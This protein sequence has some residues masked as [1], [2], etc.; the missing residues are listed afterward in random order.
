MKSFLIFL[1]RNKAY[2]FVNVFGLSISLMFI[3]LI[4]LYVYQEKSIDHQVANADRIEVWGSAFD[5]EPPCEG[6]HHVVVKY[7]MK[8]YPEI[9]SACGVCNGDAWFSIKG[10]DYT[11]KAMMVDTTF[12]H[13]FSY[14]LLQ[15][16]RRTCLTADNSIVVTGSFA[17]KV[18]GD[19]EPM[20]QTIALGDSIRYRVTGVMQDMDN[21]VFNAPDVLMNFSQQYF[22]NPANT[23]AWF[24]QGA[25]NFI[26]SSIFLLMRPGHSFFGRGQELTK[27]IY[28][29]YPEFIKTS[30][31]YRVFTVSFSGLYLSKLDPGNDVTRRGNPTLIN[32][33][34]SATL[35]IL[36][37]AVTNY[38]NLTVALSGRRAREM[39]TR[40]LF[41][42]SRRRVFLKL[43]MESTLLCLIAWVVAL[44][45]A[46][47]FAKPMSLLLDT[48]LETARLVSPAFIGLSLLLIV[49]M[50]A[51]SGVFPGLITSR[52]KPIEIIKGTFVHQTKMVLSRVFIVFQNVITIAM[53]ACAFIM[54]AQMRHLIK[55][56]MGFN[57]DKVLVVS[58]FN[59][60]H[61][62]TISTF[63]N[64]LKR[65]A[66]VA[67]VS[68]SQGTPV[69]GGNNNTV[70]MNGKK[71]SWQLF[72]ADPAFMNVYGLGLVDGSKPQPRHY[73]INRQGLAELK[74]VMNL[75]PE[76]L[77]H[78]YFTGTD[79]LDTYGGQM[80][81]FHID[82]IQREAHPMFIDIHDRIDNP[83]QI[84]IKVNGDPVDAFRTVGTIYK[85]A[86]HKEM[87]DDD[88]QFAER[89]IQDKFKTELR[90]SRLVGL[91]A[92]MAILISLLGLVAMATYYIQQRAKE[93][94]IRK[95][96]GSTDSQ[97]C[98]RLITTFLSYVAIAFIIGGALSAWL[99][100][101][102]ISQY[103]YRIVWWPWIFVAGAAVLLVSFCAIA[104]QSW[105]A[106]NENPVKNIKQE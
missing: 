76:Q 5:Q 42:A 22:F 48:T 87:T 35:A 68:A 66:C 9:E 36:L 64:L 38:I 53:L 78:F 54:L 91:F 19:E 82:N 41:G 34:I 95:V 28:T 40:Q 17:R 10:Q 46:F 11:A 83:W 102:W 61:P 25:I 52:V 100:S 15:G 69:D 75:R 84:S 104:L 90:T 1:S 50:G 18:F 45:L 7:L 89:M 56:P 92:L 51:V 59:P 21:T 101:H 31:K 60:Y 63:I 94:A 80:K 29:F 70:Q 55:A 72:I 67:D 88:V 3:M 85:Q 79:S 30:Y 24:E 44:V 32:I 6:G 93:I 73:Y 20:G 74:S 57:T 39:A 97:V 16:D 26:G 99:M 86:F 13:V 8:Q 37:F 2:T 14:R 96:F 65:E 27:F 71:A 105:Q 58:N 81:E 43:I 106:S 49:V 103:S 62:E 47:V 98:R 23:D 12:F 77:L 4:G 33:L